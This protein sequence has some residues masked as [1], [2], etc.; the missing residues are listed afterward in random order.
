MSEHLY[1]YVIFLPR[2]RKRRVLEAVFGSEV[3]IEI[4]RSAI[5][6]GVS[7]KIYQKD[8]ISTLS[9]SNKTVIDH[10]KALIELR[11]ID[12]HIEKSESAGRIVWIKYYTL[13]DLGKWFAL[14][15]A[16]EESLSSEEKMNILRNAFRS[17]TRWV[18]ELSKKLEM[19]KGELQRIFEEE[20]KRFEA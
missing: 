8:L 11:I 17:Y 7:E 4:L 18:M 1:P 3:P 6:R 5:R 16:E 2:N 19:D 13:T 14:L 15:L 12:E 9:Y 10:L 20:Y